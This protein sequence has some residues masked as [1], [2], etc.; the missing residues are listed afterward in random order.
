MGALGSMLFVRI[1]GLS[2]VD[3]MGWIIPTSR[4]LRVII[5]LSLASIF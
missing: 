3:F 5:A 1:K 2:V 4:C